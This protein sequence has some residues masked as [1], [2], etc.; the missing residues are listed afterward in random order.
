MHR[1]R[2]E[3]V[4]ELLDAINSYPDRPRYRVTGAA[5]LSLFRGNQ[6]IEELLESDFITLTYKKRYN[7][8][9]VKITAKGFQWLQNMQQLMSE[10]HN[11]NI[12]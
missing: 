8:K 2:F 1:G 3:Q 7:G 5:G 12:E 9:Y 6:L 10:V 4:V 11:G